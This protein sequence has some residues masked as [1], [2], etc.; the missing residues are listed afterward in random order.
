MGNI[1][2][3]L[4]L[5]AKIGSFS[6]TII[7]EGSLALQR[8]RSLINK[9]AASLSAKKEHYRSDSTTSECKI[10]S[11]AGCSCEAET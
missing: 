4:G 3:R 11:G 10:V 8:E 9:V 6:S 1:Q 5:S 2:N 7:A